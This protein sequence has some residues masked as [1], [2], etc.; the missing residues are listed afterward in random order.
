M[1]LSIDSLM[2][3]IENPQYEEGTILNRDTDYKTTTQNNNDDKDAFLKILLAQ[4]KYQDPL[5]P[6]KDKDFIAQM[7]QFSTVEQLLTLNKS[8]DDFKSLQSTLKSTSEYTQAI[9]LLG[10]KVEVLKDGQPLQATVTEVRTTEDATKVVVAGDEY[11]LS[12]IKKVMM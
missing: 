12:S 5:D 10:K 3:Q 11:L 2:G 9:S 7:A 1:A 6:L 4:L 8:F